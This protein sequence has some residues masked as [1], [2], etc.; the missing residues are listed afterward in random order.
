LYA[1]QRSAQTRAFPQTP[2]SPL[3]TSLVENV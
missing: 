2:K 1:G 3:F